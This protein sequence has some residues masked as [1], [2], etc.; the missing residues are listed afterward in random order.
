MAADTAISARLCASCGMCCNGVLFHAV[1]LQRGDSPRALV[2]LGMKLRSKKGIEFFLQPCSMHSELDGA[3]SCV[4]Y[5]Q[6][7]MRCRNFNCKQLER[8]A[9]DTITEEEAS[10]KI[11]AVRTRVAEINQLIAQ[12]GESNLNRSLAQRVAHA[13]TLQKGEERTT[14]HDRLEGAMIELETL[15]ENEFRVQC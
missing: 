2:S 12:F 3:C 8:V 15:L 7:P 13:L 1:N 9:S 11:H 6:R 10:E 14:L 5:D 4:I